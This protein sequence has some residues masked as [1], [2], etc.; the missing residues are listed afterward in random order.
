MLAT[1]IQTSNPTFN[2]EGGEG[3]VK[4]LTG[5]LW[6]GKCDVKPYLFQLLLKAIVGM[7]SNQDAR[8]TGDPALVRYFTLQ[9]NMVY[10]EQ[11]LF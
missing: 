6:K 3:E 10:F 9:N 8:R 1:V 11:V 4:F 7:D 5:Q 2:G